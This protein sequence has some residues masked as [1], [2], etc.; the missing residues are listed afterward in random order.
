MYLKIILG[1]INSD[2]IISFFP[3]TIT[4]TNLVIDSY[5][6]VLH[7]NPPTN[8]TLDG[9]FEGTSFNC[10]AST[11]DPVQS[12]AGYGHT[13]VNISGVIPFTDY[14]CCAMPHWIDKGNGREVCL[15]ISTMEAGKN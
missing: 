10:T 9:P 7:F 12:F 8:D 5:W 11:Y 6:F 13:S 1:H 4:V 14:S 3:G 2:I 15:N